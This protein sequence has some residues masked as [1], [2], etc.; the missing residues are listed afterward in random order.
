LTYH[1]HILT[2]HVHILTYHMYILTYHMY[3]LIYYMHISSCSIF[4][5]LNMFYVAET[6]LESLLKAV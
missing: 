6:I 5:C 3:I 4:C 1:M 2:Y